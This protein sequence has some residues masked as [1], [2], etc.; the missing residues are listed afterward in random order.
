MSGFSKLSESMPPDE[1][2]DFLHLYLSEMS[3]IILDEGGTLDKIQGDAITAFWNAP[4]DQPDHPVLAVRAALRCRDHLAEL[5]ERL[6]QITGAEAAIRVGIHTADAVVGEMGSSRSSGYTVLGSA[7][8]LASRIEGANYLF[9]TSILMS[10]ETWQRTEG[11]FEGR[12]LGEL[13]VPG[14]GGLVTLVEPLGVG[15]KVDLEP[16]EPF[17]NGLELV[18][19]GEFPDALRI[20]EQLTEDPVA[21]VYAKRLRKLAIEGGNWVGVWRQTYG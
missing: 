10:R 8:R 2:T 20:F 18:R 21:R 19:N 12:E 3:H 9:G 11:R 6:K 16:Y 4:L 14:H 15:G 5:K 13:Q 1:L 7:A 17:L